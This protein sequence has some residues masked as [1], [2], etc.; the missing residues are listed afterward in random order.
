MTLISDPINSE[1]LKYLLKLKQLNIKVSQLGNNNLTN[2]G[3]KLLKRANIYSISVFLSSK[4]R[5][6]ISGQTILL[7]LS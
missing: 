6:E 3:L 4:L 2:V 7:I 5:L 1:S